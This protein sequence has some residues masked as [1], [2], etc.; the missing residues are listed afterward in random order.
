MS[1]PISKL[2][3][4]FLW[5]SKHQCNSNLFAYKSCAWTRFWV[6]S[7]KVG[8]LHVIQHQTGFLFTSVSNSSLKALQERN[9]RFIHLD[10][11]RSKSVQSLTYRRG[12]MLSVGMLHCT[13]NLDH[14][15]DHRHQLGFESWSSP[16]QSHQETHEPIDK[17]LDVEPVQHWG[18]CSLRSSIQNPTSDR[19]REREKVR[20]TSLM[21][22]YLMGCNWDWRWISYVALHQITWISESSLSARWGILILSNVTN[23]PWKSTRFL[24]WGDGEESAAETE[25]GRL[26][27]SISCGWTKVW[28]LIGSVRIERVDRDQNLD[29]WRQETFSDLCF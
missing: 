28:L 15:V 16:S 4:P 18:W 23:H 29:F 14:E 9:W 19:E 17:R 22:R 12:G 2:R 25:R 7:V 27:G 5:N 8:K 6:S 1:H 10:F 11:A 21:M 3:K 24:F 20:R 26:T 13:H